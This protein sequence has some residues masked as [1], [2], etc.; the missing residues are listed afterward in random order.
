MK[1]KVLNKCGTTSASSHF[2]VTNLLLNL[3]CQLFFAVS[4]LFITVHIFRNC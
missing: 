3:F 4:L 2:N 1:G